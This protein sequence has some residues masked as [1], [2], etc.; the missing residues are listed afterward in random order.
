MII[1]IL[2]CTMPK[3]KDTRSTIRQEA[4]R[5]FAERGYSAVSMRELADAVGMRQSGFY[6]H[7]KSKQA[8]L[9]DLM[10]NH[11]EVLL[12]VL[13][14]VMDGVTGPVARLDAFVRHHVS[15]HLD[16]P[17]D[18]FLAYMEIRSLEADGRARI[19]A[20]R[21]RYEAVLRRIL[22]DGVDVGV[23]QIAD[24][25]VHARLL[26]SMLTGATVWFRTGGRLTREEIVA[27]H[28]QGA[29][30]GV[31]LVAKNT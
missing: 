5:L 28:L 11:M 14:D 23:F 16:Y 3:S 6:N 24:V 19:I 29:L 1:H 4:S 27:C 13:E 22:K 7:F 17:E 2:R 10:A 9:V 18:V 8:L 21:D 12:E 26:L 30:H 31:G 25:A 15:Y 20:L